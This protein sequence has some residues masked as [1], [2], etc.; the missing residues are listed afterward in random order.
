MLGAPVGIPM[1]LKV[2]IVELPLFQSSLVQ[3]VNV[4]CL[5]DCFHRLKW[6]LCHLVTLVILIGPSSLWLKN[7]MHAIDVS[8]RLFS[9]LMTFNLYDI[10]CYWIRFCLPLV[11][12]LSIRMMVVGWIV[13]HRT[14]ELILLTSSFSIVCILPLRR[15]ISVIL[16]LLIIQV[17]TSFIELVNSRTVFEK[18]AWWRSLYL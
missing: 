4:P 9:G 5:I 8:I 7:M 17:T 13:F 10:S 18:A 15:M 1:L 12:P 14:E 2:T 6:R 16:L 11:S 3:T